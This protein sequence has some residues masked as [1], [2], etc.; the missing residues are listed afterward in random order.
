MYTV[1][2]TV[3]I[4]YGTYAIYVYKMEPN[5]G[6]LWFNFGFIISIS[7]PG[8]ILCMHSITRD[9]VTMQ[10]H[11]SLAERIHKII[12]VST[13][14]ILF[15]YPHSFPDSKV[16]GTDI[17]LTWVLSAPDGPNVGPMNFAIRVGYDLQNKT[18]GCGWNGPIPIITQPGVICVHNSIEKYYKHVLKVSS[19]KC[20]LPSANYS[21]INVLTHWDLVK[22]IRISELGHH[23]LR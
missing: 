5:F 1:R 17:G 10:H 20:H 18:E 6:S 12:P 23:W 15:I 13:G 21:S 8:I 7:I 22:H 16:H 3:Y 14:F 19:S 11:L 4:F 9:D 2:T